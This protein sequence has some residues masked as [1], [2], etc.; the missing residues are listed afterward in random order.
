VTDTAITEG[1]ELYLRWARL[2][3]AMAVEM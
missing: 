2:Q 3:L 1:E